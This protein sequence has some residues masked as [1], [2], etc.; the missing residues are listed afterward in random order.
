VVPTKSARSGSGCR[1]GSAR[2]PGWLEKR[3]RLGV[4]HASTVRP[5]PSTLGVVGERGSH[6][7]GSSAR[8][9]RQPELGQLA[10]GGRGVVVSLAP[11]PA[12]PSGSLCSAT[13]TWAMIAAGP[14]SART[15]RKLD[16]S[17]RP[18]RSTRRV[19][20]SLS[21]AT[22]SRAHHLRPW[23][24]GAPCRQRSRYRG[25]SGWARP[26]T[27]AGSS[28]ADEVGAYGDGVVEK[29]GGGRRCWHA[30]KL[31]A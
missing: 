1:V 22:A 18:K 21:T 16:Q 24:S 26:A 20:P 7:E 10:E 14:C 12:L 30:G 11:R 25:R 27:R 19:A 28:A 13:R 8:P 31:Q 5:D 29:Q 15:S 4:G 9:R 17:S 2:V 6:H 23:P 3:L